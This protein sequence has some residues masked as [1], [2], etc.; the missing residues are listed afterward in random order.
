MEEH[1]IFNKMHE[2]K[3]KRYFNEINILAGKIKREIKLMEVCGSHTQVISQY[4]I[5]NV[6]PPNIKLL[7]GPGCPVCVTSKKDIDAVV[8]LALSGI[9]IAT[10]GDVIRV[11][12][13]KM[14]LEDAGRQGAKVTAVY[15]VEEIFELDTETI[16]FGIGFETTSPMSASAVKRGMRL[17]S[18][19][20][21]FIPAIKALLS[22]GQIKVDGLISP[23]HVA[24][25]VGAD[26]FQG[27]KDTK[28]NEI[29]QVIAGFEME[30]VLLSIIM[31]L[32]QIEGRKAKTENAY[33]RIVRPGGN[34]KA[35]D[36]LRE[37]FEIKDS[38]WRGLGKIS[39]TGFELR[40]KF[41][42]QD[43][44]ILY[45]DIIKNIPIASQERK[46]GKKCLCSEVIKGNIPSQK[47]PMF[48]QECTP[49]DPQGPCMVSR[50]GSCFIAYQTK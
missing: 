38:V 19:H 23:G 27:L 16:F 12:G 33:V 48:S 40:K 45:K 14:S 50:E 49:G 7:S 15:G 29:P 34:A 11:R 41:S 37:V 36:L 44:K 18:A 46:S 35:L 42:D 9:P 25:I 22:S 30:D 24:A 32:K 6:L 43:A 28:G 21:A 8:A 26:A 4:G 17:Y 31:L 3:L 10:Y 5:K 2:K 20:K 39:G 1:E 13:S 47:C